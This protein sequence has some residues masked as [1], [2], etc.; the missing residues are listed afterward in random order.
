MEIDLDLQI[1]EAREKVGAPEDIIP[2]SVDVFY[3]KKSL[4]IGK[5]LKP[6]IRDVL[7]LS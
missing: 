4:K 7:L 5:K 2:I 3:P 1:P 6:E